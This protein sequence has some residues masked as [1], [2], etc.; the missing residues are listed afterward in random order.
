M[1]AAAPALLADVGGTNVRFALADAHAAMPLLGDS[2][3]DYRVRDFDSLAAAAQ[4]Y[5]SDVGASAQRAFFAVAGRVDGDSVRMTNHH[6]HV[7]LHQTQADLGLDALRVINDFYALAMGVPLLGPESLITIGPEGTNDSGRCDKVWAVLGPGTGLGWAALMQFGDHYHVLETE[8]GHIGFAPRSEDEAKLLAQLHT[9]FVRVS[10]E[11]LVCGAGLRNI[12]Q[13]LA[14]MAGE[15]AEDLSPEQI[16]AYARDGSDPLCVKTLETFVRVF[17]AVAGDSVLGFGAWDG[18]YLAGGLV[19]HLL[20]WLQ[21][22]AF[23]ERF[24]DKGR[25]QSA[26]QRVPTRAIIHPQP[27]LLGAAAVAQRHMRKRGLA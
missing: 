14:A 19:P 25:F 4:R 2:I 1:S 11:R 22:P 23:R 18:V 15:P 6:W 10:N 12:H 16:S 27:G 21:G 24:E 13:A 9:Y 3:R 17:G 7:S 26:M 20:P 5:L 8:G